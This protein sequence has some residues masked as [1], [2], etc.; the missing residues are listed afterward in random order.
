MVVPEMPPTEE[1]L[2]S[3][4]WKSLELI[5][6]GEANT[7]EVVQLTFTRGNGSG[8]PELVL[9]GAASKR[10][11]SLGASSLVD[12]DKWQDGG[13]LGEKKGD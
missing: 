10:M 1:D 8:T 3:S 9:G 5:A 4:F 11:L 13:D 6:A 7:S 2:Q 12:S